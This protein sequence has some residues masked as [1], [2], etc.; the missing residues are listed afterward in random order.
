MYRVAIDIGGTFTDLIAASDEGDLYEAK[1]PSDRERPEEALEQGLLELASRIRSPDVSTLLGETQIIIQGTTVAINAVLQGKG[2]RTG[3]LCT[4]GFRDALEIRLGYKEE[5]YIFPYQSPPVLVPRQLRLPITERIEKTGR[6]RIPLADGDVE[7]AAERFREAEVEAVA[8]CFL[9]SFLNPEHESRAE[10]IIKARLPGVFVTK[11]VDVLPRIREYNRTSTTV[12]NA[13]V[14]PI[15]ERHVRQTEQILRNLGFE[16]RIR[17]VQSNGGL[18]EG[19]EVTQRPVLLLVSGPAAAPAAGLQFAELA[20]RNFITID[21]GGT[22]FDTCLVRDGLPDMRNFTDINRYRV[23]TPLIDVHTIGAGGGSI[24][25]VHEGLLRVG[26]ESAEAFPGPACYMRGGTEPTVTDANVVCG[27]LNPRQLLGG[28][29]TIDAD[30]ARRAVEER[31]SQLAGL[32]TEDAAA[33]IVE[34]VSHD[35]ADAIREITVR[36]GHD[37][38]DYTLIVGGGAGGLHAARLADELGIAEVVVPRVA[39]EFCAFGAVVADVRHDYTRSFVADTRNLDLTAVA[40]IFDEFE[41]EGGR[42]LLDEGVDAKRIVFVRSV[43]MRYKDQVW[44]VTIDITSIDLRAETAGLVVEERFHQ[45]HEELYDF[46]QPG[47]PCE[48]ISLTVTAIGRSSNVTFRSRET[49]S[50]SEAPVPEGSR[51][52]RFER[53]A[54]PVETPV[55]P[56]RDFLPGHSVHGPAII[57]E[58][59]TTIAVPPGWR[60]TFHGA[61]Q[62]Y[63]LESDSGRG[64]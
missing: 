43:D 16:G 64:E 45:R 8:V 33:G 53:S 36:R 13:Y 51:A 28:R 34:V 62:T 15:V 47:Y 20:G 61:E 39:S 11:S 9:W 55:F 56:G 31:V 32:D 49:A 5:R 12:L 25:A 4:R 17:Y 14:G 42:A 21:M 6:V 63:L 18:A 1:V 27:L 7:E 54:A 29:F 50:G 37:P 60:A 10:A 40:S 35:M 46:S 26:P 52:A 38:R 24:A 41:A 19:K 3:L 44:E 30:L 59:N 23:A 22:S 2:V 58:P 57:E 48:L